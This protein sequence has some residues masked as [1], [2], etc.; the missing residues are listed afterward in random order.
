[1]NDG[2][3]IGFKRAPIVKAVVAIVIVVQEMALVIDEVSGQKREIGIEIIGAG[4]RI[5]ING[6]KALLRKS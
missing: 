2:R 5:V 4:F 6:T 3:A 1:M